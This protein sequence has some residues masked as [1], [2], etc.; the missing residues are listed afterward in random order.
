MALITLEQAKAELKI[1]HTY[2][3]DVLT[4]K[5]DESEVMVFRRLKFYDGSPLAPET[6]W[7]PETLPQDFR[8]ILMQAF[9]ELYRWRGDDPESDQPKAWPSPRL[10]QMMQPWLEPTYA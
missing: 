10:L 2:E 5:L 1:D 7:T 4:R 6:P 9:V 3:D 8:A